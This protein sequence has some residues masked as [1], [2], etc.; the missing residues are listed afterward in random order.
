MLH[1]YDL[2]FHIICCLSEICG[3]IFSPKNCSVMSTFMHLPKLNL[4]PLQIAVFRFGHYTKKCKNLHMDISEMRNDRLRINSVEICA[5]VHFKTCRLSLLF[6]GF[7]RQNS[8]FRTKKFRT[9]LMELKNVRGDKNISFRN[10]S[11]DLC[12]KIK[13]WQ[14]IIPRYFFAKASMSSRAFNYV[15]RARIWEI[16]AENSWTPWN[17]PSRLSPQNLF[18]ILYLSN[19]IQSNVP[20]NFLSWSVLMQWLK[21]YFYAI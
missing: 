17:V 15:P 13:L 5:V 21:K 1:V 9:H 8:E 3:F 10:Q 14:Y 2:L 18:F 20:L 6:I 11:H 16:C 7:L 4:I 19:I 12:L